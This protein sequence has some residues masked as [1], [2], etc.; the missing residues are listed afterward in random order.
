M[1]IIPFPKSPKQQPENKEIAYIEKKFLRFM[2][3]ELNF[4]RK[5][6]VHLEKENR[7]LKKIL[8]WVIFWVGIA[9]IFWKT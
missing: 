8:G 5:D 9:L 1:K 3:Q 6:K 4:L 2:I 7:F